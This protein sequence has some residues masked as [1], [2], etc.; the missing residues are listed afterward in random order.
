MKPQLAVIYSIQSGVVFPL[1]P[2]DIV[3][4]CDEA[5]D[6]PVPAARSEYWIVER[7]IAATPGNRR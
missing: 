7:A 1:A 4:G 5:A 2:G 3:I 6:L